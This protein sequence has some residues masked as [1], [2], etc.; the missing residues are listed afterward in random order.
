MRR[1]S[2]FLVLATCL[3]AAPAGAQAIDIAPL[4][5]QA[6]QAG[7]VGFAR[8]TQ[9]VDA[10]PSVLGEIVVTIISGE[11]KET[12]SAPA[13]AGDMVVRNRCPATGNEQYLVKARNFAAS[14]DTAP[15]EPDA[16][17]WRSF[18]PRGTDMRYF[19]IASGEVR[20]T[21]TAPW[22]EA[23]VARPG[24]AIVRNPADPRDTYRIAAA[25]FTCT[26]EIVKAP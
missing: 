17:G 2:S 24:D 11:G 18:R 23:M 25:S 6:E 22:G 19:V 8:K 7:R 14:Y 4:F 5:A 20:F 10:R 1:A 13:E 12:Q 21:F 26:Y 9:L 16:Q 15:G 3:G